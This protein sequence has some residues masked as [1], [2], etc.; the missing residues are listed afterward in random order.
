MSIGNYTFTQI[1]TETLDFWK[2]NGVYESIKS[3]NKGKQK[4]YYLDGPPYTTGAIHLGHA[5]GKALRDSILRYKRMNGFDVHDQPGFDMH[6]LPIEKKVEVKLG[7]TSKADI[8]GKIGIKKFVEECKAYALEQMEPMLVDFARMGVWMDFKRPYISIHNNFIKGSWW[9]LKKAFDNDNLYQGQ[10][11]MTWCRSCET[12]LAKHELEYDVLKDQSIY[13]SFPLKDKENENLI[14]WTTTPWTIPFNLAVMVNPDEEYVKVR[15]DDSYYIIAKARVEALFKDKLDVEFEIVETFKGK[16]LE[17]V[18]YL[19]PLSE[20][21]KEQYDSVGD[22][23]HYVILSKEFVTVDDGTGLVHCAPGCGPED[24]DA[25]SKYGIK[26]LNAVLPSGSFSLVDAFKDLVAK[27]D[28][29]KFIEYYKQK[30]MIL[31]KESLRHDYACCWR[32]KTPVI[33]R[34][35]NQ[36]FLKTGQLKHQMIEQNKEI[37]WQPGWAG[38]NSFNS[39]LE[40]LQDWCISRQRYWGIPLPLWVCENESCNYVEAHNAETLAAVADVPHDLHRPYIDDV[41]LTCSKCNGTMKRTPDVLDV[42]LDSGSA[43]FAPLNY[44]SETQEFDRLMPVDFILEG[45]DQ[46]RGWFNSLSCLSSVSFGKIP[47]KAVYMHGFIQD[48]QGR[49]MSKSLGN[50]I[51]PYEVMEEYGADTMRYYM[52][53]ASKPGLDMNYNFDDIKDKHRNLLIVWN[54]QKFLKDSFENSGFTLKDLDNVELL[55]EDKY[56]LSLL[57]TTIKQVREAFDVYKIDDVPQIIEDFYLEFSRTYVQLIRD[58]LTLGDD[59]SKKAALYTC[60]AVFSDL[61]VLMAPITP[62]IVERVYQNLKD[63]FGFEYDSV[64]MVPYPVADESLINTELEQ[65]FSIAKDTISLVLSCRDQCNI[66]VRWPLGQVIVTTSK[67][68]VKHAVTHL[69]SLIKGQVNVKEIVFQDSFSDVNYELKPNFKEIGKEF[70]QD[71]ADIVTALKE[72]SAKD[73][74][75]SFAQDE[76][77]TLNVSNREFV[78][79]PHQ[80]SAQMSVSAPYYLAQSKSFNVFLDSTQNRELLSEGFSREVIRRVQN[81]RKQAGFVKTDS[82]VLSIHG[83]P[84]FLDLVGAHAELIKTKVGASTL[85]FDDGRVEKEHTFDEKVKGE[86]FTIAFEKA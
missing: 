70:S 75:E 52:I 45:K 35:T 23:R 1:E 11:V 49:K 20:E 73:V 60:K 64:H 58:R 30:S 48:A 51:S 65:D 40:S 59:A 22:N 54:L 19:H 69:S 7:L 32:C 83:Q 50:V 76:K 79:K 63:T 46:I 81:F 44:P 8:E 43:F 80:V 61:L 82:I 21:M 3:K 31:H 29:L 37:L 24:Y 34:L 42:W 66:G 25:A 77:F 41:T 67:D 39:W 62:F 26:P 17:N 56:I 27:Q 72:V 16:A 2:K 18:A 9:A 57:H 38:E 74:V 36:W 85:S 78:I 6:G 14:V 33:Y 10:R 68:S 53:G 47:F 13:V 15:V 71:T 4:F 84:D 55:T 12:A 28:D 5:W 86:E